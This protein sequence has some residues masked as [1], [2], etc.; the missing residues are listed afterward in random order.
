[1]FESSLKDF[2]T[3]SGEIVVRSCKHDGRVSRSWP[4]RVARIENSL[5][6]LDAFFAAEIR[7]Q[8]IGTIEA[9]T[10]STEF[11]WTDRWYSVYRFEAPGGRLLKFYCNLNTPPT[12]EPGALTFIDLDV[13]VLVQPDYT[14]EVLDEDEFEKHAEL[15][16]YPSDYR[17]KVQAAL[18]ELRHLIEHRKFP[19]NLSDNP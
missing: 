17:L 9:G 19:F 3:D 1:M 13:D 14:F 4:A 6:V 2:E 15:Y 7:H 12:L 16:Q 8:L 10:L 5:I 18:E 11:F